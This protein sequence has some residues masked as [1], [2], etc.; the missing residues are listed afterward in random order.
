MNY[1][2]GDPIRGSNFTIVLE[3]TACMNISSRNFQSFSY[4]PKK[5]EER[6][7]KNTY[8][9]IINSM[10]RVV[11]MFGHRLLNNVDVHRDTF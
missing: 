9:A 3:I 4:F 6:L 7:S 8:T 10:I 11:L 1:S 2:T 5:I